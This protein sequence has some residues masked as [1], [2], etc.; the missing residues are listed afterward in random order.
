MLKQLTIPILLC[1]NASVFG[2]SLGDPDL[3]VGVRSFGGDEKQTYLDLGVSEKLPHNLK[4]ELLGSFARWTAFNGNTVSIE[5]GGSD[6]ELL[7]T[8]EAP[9]DAY[10][11]SAGLA[12]ARTPARTESM[13]TFRGDYAVFK[14]G[15]NRVAVEA[16]GIW[17][18]DPL[19]LAGGTYRYQ[20]GKWDLTASCAVPVDGDNT[21]DTSTGNRTRQAVYDAGIDLDPWGKRYSLRVGVT[22]QVGWTTGTMSTAALG[23]AIG[24]EAAVTVRF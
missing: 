20:G 13:G 11:L 17:S 24:F 15:P 5:H 18:T 19:V 3:K 10:S 4:V 14:L 21:I 1:L 6:V 2:Q 12:D 22:N 23:N 16:F 8:W 9:N 7:G